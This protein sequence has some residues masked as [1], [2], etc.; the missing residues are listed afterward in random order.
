MSTVLT[1]SAPA[2]HYLHGLVC[3]Y[4]PP[5]Q[6]LNKLLQLLR[7]NLARDLNSL[8][9]SLDGEEQGRLAVAGQ[10]QSSELVGAGQ[11]QTSELV[12]ARR[13]YSS[14]PGVLGLGYE[15]RDVKVVPV[16]SLGEES[17][18]VVV[19][20]VGRGGARQAGRLRSAR[21]LTTLQVTLELGRATAGGWAGGKTRHCHSWRHLVGRPGRLEQTLAGLAAQHRTRAWEVAGVAPD[22][23]EGYQ[24]ALQGPVRP[25]MLSETLI[26]SARLTSF[27]LPRVTIQL[28]CVENQHDLA[29]EAVV[30]L[31]EEIA[32]KC[33]TVGHTVGLRCAA[34]GPWTAEHSLLHKQVRLQQVLDNININ[35]QLISRV[36]P[37]GIHHQK[38][39]ARLR[40]EPATKLGQFSEALGEI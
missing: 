29:Q 27:D 6:P 18:G 34:V 4:K 35:R 2:W 11:H 40:Q 1:H 17:S 37:D 8:E 30:R 5:G 32:V 21:Q 10:L 3:L 24:Q 23:E 28:E 20:G 39:V 13:D 31:V 19:C 14:H 33:K 7:F 36:W 26:Y 15:A 38:G 25:A 22:T 12:E 9:R 16:N